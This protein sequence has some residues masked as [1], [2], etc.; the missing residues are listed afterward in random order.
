MAGKID[1]LGRKWKELEEDFIVHTME[2]WGIEVDPYKKERAIKKARGRGAVQGEVEGDLTLPGSYDT[3]CTAKQNVL[4]EKATETYW[5]KLANDAGKREHEGISEEKV[6]DMVMKCKEAILSREERERKERERKV[7]IDNQK[8][9]REEERR[10]DGNRKVWEILENHEQGRGRDGEGN[11]GVRGDAA[12]DR[13]M[14][15]LLLTDSKQVTEWVRAGASW[16]RVDEATRRSLKQLIRESENCKEG[17]TTLVLDEIL[18]W[19][20]R[21]VN[22]IAD[23]LANLAMDSKK[24]G[25][26]CHGDEERWERL[27]K[28]D[29]DEMLIVMTDAGIRVGD[30]GEEGEVEVGMGLVVL[31][32]RWMQPMMMWSGYWNLGKIGR[33]SGEYN[34]N[35]WELLGSRL[36]LEA[37]RRLRTDERKEILEWMSREGGEWGTESEDLGQRQVENLMEL[38]PDALRWSREKQFG[39]WGL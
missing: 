35:K 34:I 13:A 29:T 39:G 38:L 18:H 9:K 36:G 16:K 21:E 1:G 20:P 11:E 17:G 4:R 26:W 12:S 14:D 22:K 37:T 33:E 3:K 32:E 25:G 7:Y 8:R 6:R 24:H 27:R 19:I 10:R 2:L 30:M 15:V 28:G 5:T 23:A 31:D